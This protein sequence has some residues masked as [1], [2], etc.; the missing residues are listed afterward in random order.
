MFILSTLEDDVRIA[1]Q[2]GDRS[3]RASLHSASEAFAA[4]R[5]S[6][7]AQAGALP[8][9]LHVK[10]LHSKQLRMSP[11]CPPPPAAAAAAAVAEH[12]LLPPQDL[13]KPVEAAITSSLERTFLDKARCCCRWLALVPAAAACTPPNH[14]SAAMVCS[15]PILSVLA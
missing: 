14:S 9:R 4:R 10:R 5:W 1:P 12:A 11:P 2:V 3:G 13:G 15:C 8:R 6:A 7:T